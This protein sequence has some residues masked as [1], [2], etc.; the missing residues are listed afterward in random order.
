MGIKVELRQGK[1][2]WYVVA[3]FND[4]RPPVSKGP[5]TESEAKTMA[6]ELEAQAERMEGV[7]LREKSVE[8]A[9]ADRLVGYAVV[10]GL[11][12]VILTALAYLAWV[13]S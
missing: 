7:K 9:R 2:W 5:M 1:R 11:G 10:G 8:E 12:A 3:D 13:L 4:G 6:A